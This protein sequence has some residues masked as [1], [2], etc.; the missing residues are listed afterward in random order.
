MELTTVV[1]IATKDRPRE[2]SNLLSALALQTVRPNM[3]VVSACDLSDVEQCVIEENAVR[4]VI[5]P[6]GLTAQ[7]NRALSLVRASYDIVIFFDDDFVPSRFW[8]ERARTLLVPQQ[9]IGCV[10]GRVLL[11]GVAGEGLEWSYGQSLVDDVDRTA[12]P[13]IQPET[14]EVRSPYGCN[15]AFLATAIEKMW[16]DERLALY[17]WLEDQDFGVRMAARAKT[18][19]TNTV[20]GVHLGSNR[21]RVSGFKFGYSQV[22]NAWYLMTK[23]ILKPRELCGYVLFGLGANAVGIILS[24][25]HVDRYGRLKGNI[26]GIIDIILNR[27]APERIVEF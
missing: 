5:G 15:M 3:I 27:W 14:K 12:S 22:V 21:G 1:I 10:T 4:L 2:L 18:I 26:V 9:R 19:W 7:R 8:I 11:D 6:P 17:G 20:W 25:S 13:I 23:G 16:F 24:N